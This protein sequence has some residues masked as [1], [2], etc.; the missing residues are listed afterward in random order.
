MPQ[1][2]R[3]PKL[4]DEARTQA[5]AWRISKGE[6]SRLT[7]K[8]RRREQA[9]SLDKG[10]PKVSPNPVYP[11]MGAHENFRYPRLHDVIWRESETGNIHTKK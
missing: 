4:L 2:Y 9:G 1:L 6:Q 8:A 7:K 3:L 5:C 11:Q 10:G